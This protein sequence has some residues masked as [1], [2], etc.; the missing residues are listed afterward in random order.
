MMRSFVCGAASFAF[1][2]LLIAASTAQGPVL[3]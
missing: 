3:G 2:A 1:T